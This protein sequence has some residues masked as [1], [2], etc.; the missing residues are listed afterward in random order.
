MN[1]R[2][3][4]YFLAV[5]KSLNFA[6]ASAELSVSASPLSRRIRALEQELGASLFI[7]NTRNVSLTPAGESLYPL[8]IE[9]LKTSEAVQNLFKPRVDQSENVN[10]GIRSVH[11]ILRHRLFHLIQTVRPEASIN[12]R[13]M[14]PEEQVKA[15]LSGTLAFGTIRSDPSHPE[16]SLLP[17]MEEEMA[18]ALPDRIRFSKLRKVDLNDLRDLKMITMSAPSLPSID[19]CRVGALS[20]VNVDTNVFGAISTLILQGDHF[21]V[22]FRDRKSP[23]RRAIEEPGILIKPIKGQPHIVTTYVAWLKKRENA[24][25][26]L[27][28]TKQIR[29]TFKVPIRI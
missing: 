18:V 16:L 4:K 22:V 17:V 24:R 10:V 21:A 25:D 7:R 26:L 6:R 3:L 27:D 2:D 11:P 28:L 19:R 20:S 29:N 8:A 12:L 23:L 15:I 14:I 13:P 9:L 5:A 1:L